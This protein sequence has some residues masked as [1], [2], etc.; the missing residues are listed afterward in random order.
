MSKEPKGAKP[1]IG[2]KVKASFG[3]RAFR[4]GG[5]SIV[6][7]ALCLAI[8]VVVN[9]LV[10]AIPSVYTKIDLT[11]DSLYTLSEQTKKLLAGL[12]QDVT[13]SWVVQSGAEDT[14]IEELMDRYSS[15]SSRITTKKID[16]VANPSLLRDYQ[17]QGIG[18]NSL[19][20]Q[21]GDVTRHIG[22]DEIVVSDYTNY[23]VDGSITQSFDGESAL[24][25]A[26]D[27][28]T[29]DDLPVVYQLTGHGEMTLTSTLASTIEKENM[30]LQSMSL[31]SLEAVPEDADA[32]LVIAPQHDIS[33]EEAE[34]LL[35]YL[36][37]G[38][39]L[40]LVS[41][42]TGEEMPNLMGLMAE[43]G[44]N[45]VDGIV[46]EGDA[47]HMLWDTPHYL[48]PDI[49][50]HTVTDPLIDGGYYA[51]MPVA[52]GIETETI[53]DTLS[54]TALLSTTS[55]AFSKLAGYDMSTYEKEEGDIDGPF[56]LGVAI[57]EPTEESNTQIVWFTSAQMLDSGVNQTVSGANE[58]LLINALGWMV[59]RE[60]SISIRSKNLMAEALI[61][62]AGDASRWSIVMIGVIPLAVLAVGILVVVKRRRA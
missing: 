52:Q 15:L 29:N 51:L 45:V 30:S 43:Y 14:L 20:V 12:D 60:N 55:S 10:G 18:N 44:A 26:L 49:A 19:L 59:E 54:I 41:E 48:L 2:E 53:R 17:S 35:A 39:N 24:T 28:V 32:V 21:S 38:G 8:V 34:R 3:R 56:A 1:G 58:D 27:Y 11:E 46:I 16:P 37:Q 7:M 33:A 47:N 22:Y 23:Y 9:L 5:Y 62:P 50:P 61:V 31:L 42:Y 25:S 57:S 4:V 36:R 6:A 13:I 40:L